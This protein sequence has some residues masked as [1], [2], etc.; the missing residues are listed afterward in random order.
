LT[1]QKLNF[2]PD[3]QGLRAIAVLAVIFAHSGL[4]ILNGGFVGVDVFFVL[5]GYLITGL[6]LREHHQ[7]GRINFAQFYARR[8]KR[9]LPAQLL[10]LIVTSALAVWLLSG[11]EA[12]AQIKS[13]PFAATWTSNL[14]FTFFSHNYFDELSGLDLFL[15]TW[16]LGVEEQFYLVWPAALLALIWILKPQQTIKEQ[17]TARLLPGLWLMLILSLA[18]S[19]YW[20]TNKPEAAF[21]LMPSR[22]W[23]FSLGAIAYA[24]LEG[25]SSNEKIQ[26]LINRKASN[27][28]LLITG[29]LLII[30]SAF[31]LDANFPYPGLWALIPSFG[32]F[33]IIAAGHSGRHRNPLTNPI[34]VWLGDRSYSLY[35][36]HWP[37]FILGFSLGYKGQ[38]L[39]T[40]VLILI[41][42]LAAMLSYRLIELPF[43]KGQLSQARPLKIILTGFL[44]IS[45]ALFVHQY[46]MRQLPEQVANTDISNKWRADLPIIYR[47]GCDAWYA[48]SD[49]NPCTFEAKDAKNTKKT[50]VLLGDSIEA[51][52]FSMVPEI[53]R[54]PLWRTIVLTKSSCPIV[55]EDI[56]YKRIGKTYQVCSDWRNKALDWLDTVKPDVVVTGNA[57]TYNFTKKQWVEG[58]TRILNRISKAAD[59]V[60]MM[61][62]TP[63]LGFDG[64]GCISRN[65]TPDGKINISACTSSGK[66]KQV[67]SVT[68]YLHLASAHFPNVFLLN[69][70]DLVCPGG[71]CNAV[72]N[73]GAVVFR[74]TQHLTNNFVRSEIPA[75]REEFKK[76]FKH[77]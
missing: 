18:L 33:L 14:Y 23:Q 77:Q 29:L 22:I 67:D 57:A 74:D 76:L 61:P 43:W 26:Q 35:L 58:T 9:L 71:V 72:S 56:F 34:L 12:R 13:A 44:F 37:I 4:D 51:Q 52:W 7:K 47:M 66:M 24:A 70:K 40:T 55:D 32:A 49:L 53:F 19:L 2:R 30:G 39:P 6:L 5:S 11:V 27:F 46:S 42:I 25:K 48:N 28:I 38:A 69:L 45:S 54:P 31:Y 3:L 50:V 73:K 36:W 15:H 20:L 21:Y 64:P 8:I 75:I 10:M 41:S 17:H 1:G 59:Q 16:S 60:V 63:G 65:M 62:G 68:G